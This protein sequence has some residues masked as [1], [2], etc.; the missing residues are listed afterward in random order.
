MAIED[1]NSVTCC[2]LLTVFCSLALFTLLNSEAHGQSIQDETIVYGTIV[3][4][5]PGLDARVPNTLLS[6]LGSNGATTAIDAD[7]K[8][9]YSVKLSSGQSY[10]L[11]VKSRLFCPVH[12]PPFD[13]RPGRRVKFDIVLVLPCPTEIF[14]SGPDEEAA[15]T[16][17]CATAGSYYCE[18]RLTIEGKVP[19][20]MVIRFCSRQT[21]DGNLFFS[22]D[23]KA[24]PGEKSGNLDRSP[25]IVAFD[26]YTVLA[27]NVMVDQQKKILIAR[28]NV[29]ITHDDGEVSAGA[30]CMSIHFG[31]QEPAI[32]SCD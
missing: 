22:S 26:T 32:Q 31:N 27:K 3:E 15:E 19:V 18:Q 6:F 25:L 5:E 30:P 17:F 10:S 2:I 7:R 4:H 14:F 28:G 11:T 8:G 29:S 1:V 24:S 21:E 20:R 16:D 23:R 9:E 13:A 12:R